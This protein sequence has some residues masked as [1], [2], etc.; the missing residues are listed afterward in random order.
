MGHG[1]EL[2]AVDRVQNGETHIKLH[3]FSAGGKA[4]GCATDVHLDWK[5]FVCGVITR[6][7]LFEICVFIE[8]EKLTNTPGMK[9]KQ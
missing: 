8:K 7:V 9:Y 5:T 2:S 4:P 3:R 1:K 6:E